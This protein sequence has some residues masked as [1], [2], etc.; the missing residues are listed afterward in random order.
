MFRFV[1]HSYPNVKGEGFVVDT[2]S[3]VTGQELQLAGERT[4]PKSTDMLEESY[5]C[6][7]TA[8]RDEQSAGM[9][10]GGFW[11][12]EFFLKDKEVM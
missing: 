2:L 12:Q 5:L 1:I 10:G 3:V 9:E 6:P 8:S 11:N 4:Q 7:R